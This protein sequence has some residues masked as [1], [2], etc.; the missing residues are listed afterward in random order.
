MLED[1]DKLMLGSDFEKLNE[2]NFGSS[3]QNLVK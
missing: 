3:R 1:A 2:Y